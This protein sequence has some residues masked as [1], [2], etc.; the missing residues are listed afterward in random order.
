MYDNRAKK[1]TIK[2][3]VKEVKNSKKIWGRKRGVAVAL[4]ANWWCDGGRNAKEDEEE[5][6]E[7]FQKKAQFN[8]FHAPKGSG[9]QTMCHIGEIWNG[10]SVQ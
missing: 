6:I 1:I 5:I 9:L 10:R 2:I 8:T 3:E 7:I 4:T